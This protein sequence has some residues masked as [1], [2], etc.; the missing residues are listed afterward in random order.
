MGKTVERVM[1]GAEVCRIFGI[2]PGAVLEIDLRIGPDEVEVHIKR[3]LKDEEIPGLL[4]TLA[5]YELAPKGWR[6]MLPVGNK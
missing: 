3:V 6:D 1:M 2:E 4:Q 5:E